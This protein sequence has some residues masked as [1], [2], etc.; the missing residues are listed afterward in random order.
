MTRTLLIASN[1]PPVVGGACAVYHNLCINSDNAMVVLA[2]RIDFITG[3][4]ID[5]IDDYDGNASFKI[6]RT[7]LLRP[8]DSCQRTRWHHLLSAV[9]IDIPL[10]IRVL[11]NVVRI[12]FKEKISVICICDLQYGGWLVYIGKYL[13]GTK[14]I[15]YAHGEEITTESYSFLDRCRKTFLRSFDAVVAV[16]RFTEAAL[17]SRMNVAPEAIALIPNGVDTAKFRMLADAGD[18]LERL[19]LAGRRCV[20]GVGRLVERKGFDQAIRAMPAILDAVPNVHYLIVGEGPSRS[21]LENLIETLGLQDHVTL[22]GYVDDLTL[23]R[24][25]A[26]CELFLMPNRT[27]ANGDT[28]GFGL[29]FL[30]ANACGLPAVG[31]RAGGAVDAILHGENGLLVNSENVAD[32]ATA[33]TSI[34]MDRVLYERLRSGGLRMADQG[35]WKNRAADF[36]RLCDRLVHGRGIAK[37]LVSADQSVTRNE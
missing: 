5:Q 9:L 7:N 26:A 29:V 4:H 19:G 30:E 11:F 15:Y 34:L 1:F 27:L 31:G 24:I 36:F 28:E 33:V 18:V 14:M 12:T 25:Y 6:Y 8:V 32:I 35:Q 10:M 21:A 16:S 20:L 2:P 3:K 22:L 37:P 13:L 17:I 23:V